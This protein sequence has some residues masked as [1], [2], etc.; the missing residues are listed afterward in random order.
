MA[1]L[2]AWRAVRCAMAGR[3]VVTAG[4]GRLPLA[5]NV[6][7]HWTSTRRDYPRAASTLSSDDAAAAPRGVLLRRHVSAALAAYFARPGPASP[8]GGA[9]RALPSLSTLAGRAEY[10]AG[11]ARL[12]AA[13]GCAWLTPSELFSPHY[14]RAVAAWVL[15]HHAGNVESG[16][17]AF[18]EVGAGRGTLAADVLDAVRARA[19]HLYARTTYTTLER[20][21]T[22]AAVQEARVRGDGRHAGFVVHVGDA[23]ERHVWGPHDRAHTYILACEVLDNLAHDLVRWRQEGWWQVRVVGGCGGGGGGGR[24]TS[25]K[26]VPLPSLASSPSPPGAP[27]CLVLEPAT[28]PLVMRVLDV[29]ASLPPRPPTACS[30]VDTAVTWVLGSA[31]APDPAAYLPTEALALF[32]AAVAARPNHTLLAA[33]FDALP[34]PEPAMRAPVVAATRGGRAVDYPS[35]L[36]APPGGADIFFPT[37]FDLAAGLHAAA[38]VKAGCTPLAAA[39]PKAAEFLAAHADLAATRTRSGWNPLLDDFDNTSVLLAECREGGG[40][41]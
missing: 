11:V 15:E 5:P 10:E 37:D 21:P 14:G 41:S 38:A 36:A 1:A 3:A 27:L 9:A 2:R 31:S 20:S 13:L 25:T 8:V 30:L 18:V 26:M 17:L 33:D 35:I 39:W 12:Y 24:G 19:P 6:V 23:T 7:S 32:D 4:H 22:L 34:S 40:M 16:E 29:E 28:D